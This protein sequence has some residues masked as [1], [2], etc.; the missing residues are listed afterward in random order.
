[1]APNWPIADFLRFLE[2]PT[3][4]PLN[5]DIPVKPCYA[6]KERVNREAGDQ[7]LEPK[8]SF[9]HPPLMARDADN[10]A[11]TAERLERALVIAAKVALLIGGEFD[12]GPMLDVLERALDNVKANNQFDKAK[13]IL[14]TYGA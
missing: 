14:A 10:T 5:R 6:R 11:L 7:C 1:M 2:W 3:Q 12:C 13:A 9:L 8:T 4:D